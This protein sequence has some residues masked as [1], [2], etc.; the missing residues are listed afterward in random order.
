MQMAAD[1]ELEHARMSHSTQLE[2]QKL[3]LSHQYKV[4]ENNK[5]I[6]DENYDA[7][8][9]EQLARAK[10]EVL[11]NIMNEIR[12]LSRDIDASRPEAIMPVRDAR[13]R[14]VGGRIRTAGGEVRDIQIQ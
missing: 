4:R 6:Q 12:G 13:G 10:M 5:A 8:A 14:V 9:E 7:D 1:A 3:K 11:A 2:S